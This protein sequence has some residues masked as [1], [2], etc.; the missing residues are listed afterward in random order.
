M[1]APFALFGHSLGAYVALAFTR[2]LEAS[3]RTRPARLIVSAA[4]APDSRV[5]DSAPLTDRALLERIARLGGTPP[6]LLENEQM[7]KIM[8]PVL[9]ADYELLTHYDS[10]TTPPIACPLSLYAGQADP[11]VTGVQLQG[12]QALSPQ[13]LTTRLFPGGHFYLQAHE[14]L[15]LE[16]LVRDLASCVRRA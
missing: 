4:A 15:F 11:S 2:R 8:L 16:M 5:R 9:H 12:W 3:D 7:Q 6:E 13:P 10:R 14:G 1:T